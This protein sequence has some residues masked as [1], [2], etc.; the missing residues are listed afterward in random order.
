MLENNITPH[1]LQ[2]R[3]RR[4]AS[5]GQKPAI[6]W[7][8]GLSGTGKSTVAN[9]VDWALTARGY[10]AMVLDGDN[11]RLGLNRDLG[12]TAQDRAENVRRT[13]ETAR[14]M[15]ES[16][17]ITMVALISPSRIERQAARAIA[18]DIPFIEVFV[19]APLEVVESRDPKGLYKR[20][21]KGEIKGL[22]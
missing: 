12:F 8:T 7:L 11:L 1:R 6:V 20:A 9:A 4:W 22:Y 21:R 19:D 14:L 5:L 16:G 10:H 2:R 15:G 18:G 17:L 13:A 3:E